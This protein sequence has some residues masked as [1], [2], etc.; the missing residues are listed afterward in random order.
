M[1]PEKYSAWTQQ[2][3]KSKIICKQ[4]YIV[5]I[6]SFSKELKLTLEKVLD[7][8]LTEINY[9]KKIDIDDSPG[10]ALA[11]SVPK[12]KNEYKEEDK[13]FMQGLNN[14]EKQL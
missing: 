8:S 13:K 7:G 11:K 2:K 9:K 4:E 12:P 14:R 10:G 6:S 1:A 5:L 3:G